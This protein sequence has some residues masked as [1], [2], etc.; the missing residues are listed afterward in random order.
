VENPKGR[1]RPKEKL[2]PKKKAMKKLF[3]KPLN[4]PS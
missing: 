1:A 3:G 2:H 4:M